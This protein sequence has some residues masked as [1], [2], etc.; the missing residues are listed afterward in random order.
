M[1]IKNAQVYTEEFAFEKR[2]VAVEGELFAETAGGGT[3]DAS[4]LLMLP[5]LIDIHSHGCSGYDSAT[6]PTRRSTRLP[7]M[8]AK[9][10]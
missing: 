2:D 5:G 1:I 9:T 4:G 3:V 7:P 10:A 6:A 8:R